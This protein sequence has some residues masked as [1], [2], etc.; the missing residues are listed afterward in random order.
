[1]PA[2]RP[3]MYTTELGLEICKRLA[4]PESLLSICRDE[5]MPD[6]S[7]VMEWVL[8][9]PEFSNNYMRARDLQTEAFV[10]EIPDI[11]DNGTND[12]MQRQNFDGAEVGW[13]LNGEA[14]ARS[15]LRIDA[16]K[17]I[18]GQ[19]KP[20][21]YGNRVIQAGDEEMPLEMNVTIGGQKP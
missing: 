1:M 21:K 6:R 3:S 18:A 19:M 9:N 13:H 4:A 12:W 14:Q 10:D 8:T 16:R 2:G 5:G 17:W 7:T 11:A 20:K 15:R